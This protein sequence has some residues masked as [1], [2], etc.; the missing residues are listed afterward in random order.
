ML[1]VFF[2]QPAQAYHDEKNLGMTVAFL[3]HVFWAPWKG[4]EDEEHVAAATAH[5]G[6]LHLRRTRFKGVA[7][8]P[9]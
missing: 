5:G 4:H 1:N 7:W 2:L 9:T 6:D 3:G 8:R